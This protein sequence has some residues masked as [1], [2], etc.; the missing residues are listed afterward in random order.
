MGDAR[1]PEH[2]EDVLSILQTSAASELLVRAVDAEKA[3]VWKSGHERDSVTVNRATALVLI[4]RGATVDRVS[5]PG[6]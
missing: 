4:E 3:L 6:D 2:V 1:M 5:S